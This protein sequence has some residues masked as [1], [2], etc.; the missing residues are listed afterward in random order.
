[1]SNYV[2]NLEEFGP[3]VV[4]NTDLWEEAE[5][6]TFWLRL[7]RFLASGKIVSW[8]DFNY[9]TQ[10]R[11]FKLVQVYRGFSIQNMG[12]RIFLN[13]KGSPKNTYLTFRSKDPEGV[14]NGYLPSGIPEVVTM[15]MNMLGQP[16]ANEEELHSEI[17]EFIEDYLE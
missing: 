15:A 13:F 9:D 17:L 10:E 2:R 6:K 5:F 16:Y 11:E 12:D 1:M 8:N 3:V 4:V 14:I 7:S